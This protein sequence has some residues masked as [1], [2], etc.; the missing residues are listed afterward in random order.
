MMKTIENQG[1]KIRGRFY[2]HPVRLTAL[3]YLKEALVKEKYELCPELIRTAR[4]FG[5]RSSEIQNLLEDPRRTP[6]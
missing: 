4:E 2:K 1:E 5:A 6:N 3:L